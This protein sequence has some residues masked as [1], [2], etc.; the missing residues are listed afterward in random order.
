MGE[1]TATVWKVWLGL[2]LALVMA[3][4]PPAHAQ[5]G[6]RA[7]KAAKA[8]A[9]TDQATKP[10]EESPATED[11]SS[12]SQPPTLRM[13]RAVVCKSI[14]GYE[15]YKPL[16]GAAQTSEEK[17]LI[18]FRPLRYNVDYVDGY[19][20]AHLV[21]DN[22][23]RRRGRKEVVRQKKKVVEY[24]PKSKD[25]LGPIFI[26]NTISLKGLQPG[27]YE[28]TIILRDELDREAAPTRQVVS[29]KV[30]PPMDPRKNQSAK[31]DDPK[32]PE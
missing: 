32:P 1:R 28:L 18:Y 4:T 10:D 21:Q 14:D 8:A 3:A 16:P 29:F 11:S 22:E 19:Y 6:R 24:D 13:S 2:F 26:R 7:R 31:K 20:R 15:N 30:I 9:K 25:P 12:P 5:S 17:L 27:D 23:I